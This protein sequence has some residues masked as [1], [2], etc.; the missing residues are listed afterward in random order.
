MEVIDSKPHRELGK[1]GMRLWRD[2]LDTVSLDDTAS[3]EVLLLAA[4][5]L[6]RAED[7]RKQIARDGAVLR[8]ENRPPRDHPLLKIELANRS[9]VAKQLDKLGLLSAP[10]R[11]GPGRPTLS[12]RFHAY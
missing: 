8:S 10:L 2:V 7:C 12:E 6:D 5:A 11:A 3:R 4:E 1:V 9:F